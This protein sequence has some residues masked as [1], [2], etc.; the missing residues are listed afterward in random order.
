MRRYLTPVW[1]LLSTFSMS[2]IPTAGSAAVFGISC[3]TPTAPRGL[4]ADW[5]SFDSW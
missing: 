2:G 5:S 3:I 1:M 4:R